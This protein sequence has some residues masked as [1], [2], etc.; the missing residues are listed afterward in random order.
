M[1]SAS[2]L[3][4]LRKVHAELEAAQAR[5]SR[6]RRGPAPRRAARRAA[7]GR[8][9]RRRSAPLPQAAVAEKEAEIAA[10]Q[11]AAVEA[12]K[13]PFSRSFDR[14]PIKAIHD[15]AGAGKSLVRRRP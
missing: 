10:T 7:R 2:S 4:D 8:S 5:A 15:S 12:L 6:R 9:R 11:Q 1:A 13:N 3:E 14:T